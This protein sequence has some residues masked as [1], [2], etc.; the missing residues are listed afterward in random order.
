MAQVP[1]LEVRGLCKKHGDRMAVEDVSFA[2]AQGELVVLV[3]E[4]G[5]GKTTTLKMINR[6]LEA[7]GGE[8]LL[9]GRDVRELAAVELRRG[10]GY[11]FQT[12]GLFP[13]MTVE[14]NVGITLELSG[15]EESKRRK[16]VAELLQLV[17]LSATEF[18]GRFP[19]Q[20]SG[21][22]RQRV[23]FARALAASPRVLLLDEPF[24]ALDPITRDVLQREFR[25]IQQ[26]LKP[27]VVLVTH[28]MTEALS[29]ADRMLIMQQGRILQHGTPSQVLNSP[30][31][32]FVTRLMET[33]RRQA[34]QF[35]RL[36]GPSS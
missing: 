20:L 22:Q 25:E 6:L 28:D 15:W 10:I 16:R 11:V 3:G 21:G 36:M 7:D 26:R 13:H 31:S 30:Q 29:L 8:V 1:A 33:P 2:V 32:G 34:E 4:S 5:C 12:A 19:Q 35:E 9:A 23:S 17:Q 14:Q 27:A 18:R 24:G